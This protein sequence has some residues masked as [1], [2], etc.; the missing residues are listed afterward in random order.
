[1]TE[2]VLT[3]LRDFSAKT[4]SFDG[5]KPSGQLG[6]PEPDP[7]ALRGQPREGPSDRGRAEGGEIPCS[8][9]IE[10]ALAWLRWELVSG[11]LVLF[12][13]RSC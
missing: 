12:G 13:F 4:D 8:L 1:M 6:L 2:A 11:P 7:G 9:D 10:S 5:R 3:L